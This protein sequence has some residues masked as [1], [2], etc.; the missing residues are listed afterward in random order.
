MTPCLPKSS[1]HLAR[2]RWGG[3]L[4]ASRCERELARAPG[5]RKA[6]EGLDRRFGRLQ[7]CQGHGHGHLAWGRGGPSQNGLGCH[8]LPRAGLAPAGGL[9]RT[10]RQAPSPA[11]LCAN[12]LTSAGGAGPGSL[13]ME[14][15]P[16][17]ATSR[18]KEEGALKGS[19]AFSKG[20]MVTA[21]AEKPQPDW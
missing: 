20:P 21:Q 19:K 6:Q 8:G 11:N 17:M 7:R 2:T 4:Q 16:S 18:P 3:A 12:T 15:R 1:E 9:P 5:T 14:P 13:T 10:F